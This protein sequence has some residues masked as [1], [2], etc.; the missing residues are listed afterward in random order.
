MVIDSPKYPKRSKIAPKLANRRQQTTEHREASNT[1]TYVR[2]LIDPVLRPQ[3]VSAYL[4]IE[5]SALPRLVQFTI[6]K[7]ARPPEKRGAAG[8]YSRLNALL[9]KMGMK[10]GKFGMVPH[11]IRECTGK[12]SEWVIDLVKDPRFAA[13]TDDFKLEK[14]SKFLVVD[15]DNDEG[16]LKAEIISMEDFRTAIL[17][18]GAHRPHLVLY[19]RGFLDEEYPRLQSFIEEHE[20][21]A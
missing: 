4:E 19:L 3:D 20:K 8:R 12:V 2:H 14:L 1:L 18:E 17:K 7:P 16:E 11:R 21:K 5:G 15:F 13:Q 6:G 10:V 9:I